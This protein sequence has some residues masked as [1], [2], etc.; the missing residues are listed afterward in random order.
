MNHPE[1]ITSNQQER[2]KDILNRS[3]A[4]LS[5][6]GIAVL[7]A[8]GPN[9]EAQSPDP[10]ETTVSTEA[11]APVETTE[12]PQTPEA[13][14][15]ATPESLRLSA[16]LPADQLV[17]GSMELWSDWIFAGATEDTAQAT[18]DDWM[19]YFNGGLEDY[20]NE[21]AQKSGD[22]YAA[23]LLPDNWQDDPYAS[24]IYN[25]T[26]NNNK[27]MLSTVIN[28]KEN[29]QPL[30]D[31][32]FTVSNVVENDHTSDGARIVEFDLN[33]QYVNNETTPEQSS[34]GLFRYTVAE[35]GTARLTEYTFTA[36]TPES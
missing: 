28:R 24:A 8:C 1:Q 19:G 26:V 22:F 16:E 4:A 9:A 13:T 11:P 29:N 25:N 17:E 5:A 27:E 6:V 2:K 30:I 10:V 36:Q 7:A 34:H 3:V 32:S 23:A 12:A 35:D 15:S 20:K 14:P 33:E 18:Y 31:H 21:V